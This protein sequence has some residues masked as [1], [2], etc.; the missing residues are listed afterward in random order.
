MRIDSHHNRIFLKDQTQKERKIKQNKHPKTSAPPSPRR[1]PSAL[2]M[3]VLHP[4]WSHQVLERGATFCSVRM[5]YFIQGIP[6]LLGRLR[7]LAFCYTAGCF[8]SSDV[9]LRIWRWG[10]V[11]AGTL[12]AHKGVRL[13]CPVEWC[14]LRVN[15]EL[16]EGKQGNLEKRGAIGLEE[17][18]PFL[19]STW[20]F[21]VESL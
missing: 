4:L 8:L 13:G 5:E 15:M 1:K 11:V 7:K 10:L 17:R 19:A 21:V 3:H 14:A 9:C 20:N 16:L 2:R 18:G 12:H 6:P